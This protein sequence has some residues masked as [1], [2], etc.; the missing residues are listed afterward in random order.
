VW[1]GVDQGDRL[2]GGQTERNGLVGLWTGVIVGRWI[3]VD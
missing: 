1:T 2:V 3:E